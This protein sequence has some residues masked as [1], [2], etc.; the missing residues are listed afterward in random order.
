MT[1]LAVGGVL[2]R[3]VPIRRWSR[4]LGEAV[5]VPPD[6][7]GRTVR[8][9]VRGGRA[10][11][12]RAEHEVRTAVVNGARRLPWRSTCLAEAFAAQVMLRRRGVGG[13]VVVGLRR[14]GPAWDAHAWLVASSGVLTGGPAAEGFTATSVFEVPGGLSARD[15]A[16][17]GL[18][19]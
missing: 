1:L 10:G 15:L 7:A 11:A 8:E 12:A 13:V 19:S 4:A 6:W 17:A 5:A 9:H 3:W 14:H 16:S 2:Q 18:V